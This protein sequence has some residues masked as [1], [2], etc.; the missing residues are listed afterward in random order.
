MSSPNFPEADRETHMLWPADARIRNLTYG[1]NLYTDVS[2]KCVIYFLKRRRRAWEC[3][4]W[5]RDC[6]CVYMCVLGGRGVP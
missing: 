4:R 1:C 5:D 3:R 6:V 2:V